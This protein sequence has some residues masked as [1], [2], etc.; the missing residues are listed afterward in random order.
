MPLYCTR[1]AFE[2]LSGLAFPATRE[3]ILRY[4][5]AHGAGAMEPVFVAL[6]RLSPDVISDVW[7]SGLMRRP[8]NGARRPHSGR[9]DQSR[10][11]RHRLG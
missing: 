7:T 10:D 11:K 4:A 8:R 6:N 2:A 1:Q 9:V 3:Q 5:A